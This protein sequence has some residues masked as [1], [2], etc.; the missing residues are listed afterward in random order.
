[1]LIERSTQ[2][3]EQIDQNKIPCKLNLDVWRFVSAYFSSLNRLGCVAIKIGKQLIHWQNIFHLSKSNNKKTFHM[4][5]FLVEMLRA[6]NLNV[7][8]RST[9]KTKYM[10]RQ[11]SNNGQKTGYWSWI[12]E[13][14]HVIVM[15]LFA[16]RQ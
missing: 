15:N 7:Q 8:R 4:R 3:T 12:N 11:Q 5:M 1:M 6:Q 9:I 2:S 13:G 16:T 10:P 14:H